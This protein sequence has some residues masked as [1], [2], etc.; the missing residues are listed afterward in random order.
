[1]AVSA[2]V[3]AWVTFLAGAVAF[4][5]TTSLFVTLGSLVVLVAPV[6]WIR[7]AGGL[8]M[9]AYGLWEF[10]GVVGQRAVEKEEAR[11]EKTGTALKAFVALVV[12]LALLDITGDATEILTIVYVSQYGDLLLVF[13]GC[14][15]GLYAATAVEA[16]LGSALKRI[17]T[18]RR[19]RYVSSAVFLALGLSILALELF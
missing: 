17:L 7:L 6:G 9:V 1:L 12:A 15:L 4:T 3:K 19:L 18:P 8:V 2:R 14:L 16:A 13:T 10:R 11:V 5:L